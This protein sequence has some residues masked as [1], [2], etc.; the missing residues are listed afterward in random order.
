[1]WVVM[2]LFCVSSCVGEASITMRGHLNA[3]K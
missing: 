3:E 1:M 2:L